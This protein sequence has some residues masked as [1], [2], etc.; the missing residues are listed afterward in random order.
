MYWSSLESYEVC[1]RSYLWGHGYGTI[2]LGRGPGRSKAK[3]VKE[4]RHHAVMGLV[5][6]KAVEHLYNDELWRDPATLVDRLT[7]LVTREFTFALTEEYIDW[8]EAPAK[9]DMLQV[10]LKGALGY[11]RTMKTNKLLGPY[12]RSEV[13]LKGWVD[14]YTPVGGKPDVIVR[15]DDNGVSIFDGKNAM[16]PGKYTDPNQLVWYALCFYLAYKV[17]PNRLAFVYFRY[18]EGTPPRDHPKDKPWTGL[19][20]VPVTLD[21]LMALGVRAKETTRAMQK[22]L[23]DPTPSPSAC[24]FCHYRTVCDA[25]HQPTPRGSKKSLPLVEGTVEHAIQTS[26]GMVEFGFDSGVK[27]PKT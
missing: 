9:S 4:S 6:A 25:A 10:C 21:D 3:P 23:F 12:A 22:E 7:T 19:V 27:T 1:P 14:Q 20:E 16:T 2:D 18:P 17:V 5:L 24:R 15:R 11:L 13:D 26:D 8:T